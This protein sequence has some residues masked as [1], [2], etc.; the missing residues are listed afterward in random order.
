LQ[1][2][3]MVHMLLGFMP[4]CHLE[5][6]VRMEY[7]AGLQSY[8]GGRQGVALRDRHVDGKPT[9]DTEQR[10]WGHIMSIISTIGW[11]G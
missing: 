5:V 3:G 9:A 4:I 8:H 7:G 11:L 10:A 2:Q 1:L 6:H